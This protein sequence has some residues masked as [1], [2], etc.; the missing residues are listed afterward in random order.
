MHDMCLLSIKSNLNKT[1]KD[2]KLLT[3]SKQIYL[4]LVRK[5]KHKILIHHFRSIY[6][7]ENNFF[8][9]IPKFTLFYMYIWW[10][11]THLCM[12]HYDCIRNLNVWQKA[13]VR[14][15]RQK[16]SNKNIFQS[17]HIMFLFLHLSHLHHH[18]FYKKVE[19][20]YSEYHRRRWIC[21]SFFPCN[22]NNI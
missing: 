9:N 11:T 3:L 5:I 16:K 14:K 6:M 15:T 19:N 8:I 10:K 21:F 22:N 1:L 7:L 4:F 12:M 2:L 20:F 18:H 13:H 17:I